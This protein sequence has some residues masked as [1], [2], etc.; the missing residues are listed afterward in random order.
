MQWIGLKRQVT[1]TLRQYVAIGDVMRALVPFA[2]AFALSAC[3]TSG[4]PTDDTDV[5]DT[6]VAVTCTTLPE[7]VWV[8]TGN[9][10]GMTMSGTLTLDNTGCAF[11]FSDWN[12][13]MDVPKGGKVAGDEVTFT[14]AGWEDC[15]GTVADDVVTG[16]CDNGCTYEMSPQ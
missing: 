13:S 6:D 14:G 15:T 16:G 12:M 7:G 3:G 9:C 2:L 5:A 1:R 11:T 10:F 8:M 4:S